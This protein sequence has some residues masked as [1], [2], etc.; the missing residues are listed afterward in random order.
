LR[1]SQHGIRGTVSIATFVL[2]HQ[3]VTHSRLLARAAVIRHE[4]VDRETAIVRLADQFETHVWRV[5]RG[6]S[7]GARRDEFERIRSLST[8]MKSVGEV[9]GLPATRTRSLKRTR[10]GLRRWMN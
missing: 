7:C 1:G 2:R 8:A 3:T 10:C 9:M 5:S 4:L 6:N